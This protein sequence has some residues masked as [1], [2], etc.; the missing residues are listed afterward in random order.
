MIFGVSYLCLDV[1][2][3]LDTLISHHQKLLQDG[4]EMPNGDV[5]GCGADYH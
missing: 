3:H 2:L 4:W 1:T 5:D